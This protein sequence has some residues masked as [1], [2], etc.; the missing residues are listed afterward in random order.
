MNK[1]YVARVIDVKGAFLKGK[2]A[3]EEEKLMLE[4]P[5][6]FCWVYDKL[7]GEV[8]AKQKCGQAMSSEEVMKRA[9]E[10][11]GEWSAKPVG[12]KLQLVQ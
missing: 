3:S 2:F 12:E 11:F 7:G 9:K 5:Q 8:E 1:C 10:I 6:G 4:V